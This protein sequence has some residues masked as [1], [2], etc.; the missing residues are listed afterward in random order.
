MLKFKLKVMYFIEFIKDD[1][2][3]EESDINFVYYEFIFEC[4]RSLLFLYVGGGDF[5]GVFWG[6]ES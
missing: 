5:I 1:D 4:W 2:D 3:Y 6:D